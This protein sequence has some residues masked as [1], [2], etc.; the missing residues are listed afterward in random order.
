MEWRHPS[1]IQFLITIY[2]FVVPQLYL[3]SFVFDSLILKSAVDT[4]MLIGPLVD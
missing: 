2:F 1:F 3:E 4:M